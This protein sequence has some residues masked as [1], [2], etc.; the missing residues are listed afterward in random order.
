MNIQI[1]IYLFRAVVL[2][3]LTGQCSVLTLNDY[4]LVKVLQDIVLVIELHGAAALAQNHSW[5]EGR[6]LPAAEIAC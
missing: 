5:A 3:H 1:S 2:R 6:V 4:I